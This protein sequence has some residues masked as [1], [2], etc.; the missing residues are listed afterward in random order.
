MAS[1]DHVV[2]TAT[3]DPNIRR[4]PYF[5]ISG[6][7]TGRGSAPVP[8]FDQVRAAKSESDHRRHRFDRVFPNCSV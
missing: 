7:K 8:P 1:A 6:K 2:V 5:D 4:G 3:E